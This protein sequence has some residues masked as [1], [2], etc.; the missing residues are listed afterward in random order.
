VRQTRHESISRIGESS[1]SDFY[2]GEKGAVL[3]SP[4]LSVKSYGEVGLPLSE[5]G[6]RGIIARCRQ[7]AFGKGEQTIIDDTVR[8]SWEL[9]NDEFEFR[10][11]EFDLH[12]TSQLLPV[13]HKKFGLACSLEHLRAEPYKML[14][15]KE[16]AF[17]KSHQDSEKTPGMFGTLVVALPFLHEGGKLVLR[18]QGDCKKFETSTDS[19]FAWSWAAW[20]ADVFHRL[21]RQNASGKWVH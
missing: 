12:I 19:A 13:I 9:N 8:R 21:F 17:F 1:S 6:A 18:H 5:R 20:F 16:G 7:S 4:G 3:P 14:I 10:N 2:C 15:Y 11:A